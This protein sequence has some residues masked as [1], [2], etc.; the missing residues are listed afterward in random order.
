VARKKYKNISVKIHPEIHKAFEK[1]L[2]AHNKKNNN[3][4]YKVRVI[5]D[6]LFEAMLHLGY[7][8]EEF[9]TEYLKSKKDRPSHSYLSYLSEN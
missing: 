6:L 7:I 1:S 5:E 8:K 3:K 4:V 9:K 2:N